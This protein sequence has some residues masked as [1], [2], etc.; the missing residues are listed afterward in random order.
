M[1]RKILTLACLALLLPATMAHAAF[2]RNVCQVKG[3]V[4]EVV[5]ADLDSDG[6][7][8][9]LV[10]YR[11]GAP[12]DAQ[13]RLAIFLGTAQGY[14]GAPD[15]DFA[16][17]ADACVF[18]LADLDGDGIDEVILFRKWSV[19]YVKLTDE[20]AQSPQTLIKM[21]SG[22]LFPPYNG[23]LPYENLV[24]DWS[25][26]GKIAVALP[27]YGALRMFRPDDEGKMVAAE[28]LTV[29]LRSWI[30]T[31]GLQ[32]PGMPD[33]TISSTVRFP[34]I[35]AGA[36]QNERDLF[37]ARGES[38]W[39]YRGA[40]GRFATKGQKF[41]LPILTPAER[42]QENM[43]VLT[44]IDDIDGDGRVDAMINKFGGGLTNFSSEV[45]I[46]RG[47]EGGFAAKPGFT[48]TASG[49]MAGL[50]FW[51]ID[52]DGRKEMGMPTAEIGL[53]QL[54]RMFLSKKVKVDVKLFA[55]RG[56]VGPQMYAEKPTISKNV[57]LDLNTDNG[58]LIGF[59]PSF[60]G[61]FDG[62][63]KPDF[64]MAHEDGFGVWRN[65]GNMRIAAEPF[66]TQTLA[67]PQEYR[68]E[69]L[70]NDKKSDLLLWNP[71]DPTQDNQVVVL[72][73]RN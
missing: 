63:G 18:D 55:C 68:L 39:L 26:D 15:M 3:R 53:V 40:A 45:H 42:A 1:N 49:Y 30:D 51:D 56:P 11:F 38:L 19:Q 52:G 2:V 28:T 36:R 12:P 54:A 72:L 20:G 14:T 59:V 35:F 65:Q 58:H 8:D 7:T 21:G 31:H 73:N 29:P 33:Y 67:P 23:Q 27:D 34:M 25:G 62:D 4:A 48:L 16:A 71:A 47:I 13:A 41:T 10:S 61:D 46:H 32:P 43:N 69:Y 60:E 50:R 66:L 57:T 17:P 64:F 5:T 9:L 6:F 24:R 70:D 22:I 44:L 37:L